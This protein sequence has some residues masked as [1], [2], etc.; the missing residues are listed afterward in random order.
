MQLLVKYVREANTIDT[1]IIRSYNQQIQNEKFFTVVDKFSKFSK[2]FHIKDRSAITIRSKIIKILHFFTV[3]LI[4]VTDN[5]RGF[6]SPI[7]INLIKNLGV[8]LYLTPSH[9]SEVNGQIERVHSTIL[10][11][12]RCFK[13]DY[14]DLSVKELVYVAVDRYNNTVHS[15]IQRKPS[16]VFFNRSQR[17]NYQNLLNI[18]SRINNDLRGLKKKNM[19]ARNKRRNLK[20]VVPKKY[21]NGDVVYVASKGIKSKNKP[22]YQKEIVAKDNR[23]TITTLSGKKIH[24]AHLKNI[25]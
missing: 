6:L 25:K 10:E 23:V 21:K 18:R 3:P 19:E 15:V 2:F 24:K 7:V 1:R 17:V 14:R 4:L 8:K 13:A 5:E 20:R 16:D 11:I 9:R 22:L 12:Y